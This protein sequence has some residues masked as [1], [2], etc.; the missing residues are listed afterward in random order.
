MAAS[1]VP[2]AF[3][4]KLWF[5]CSTSAGGPTAVC[6]LRRAAVLP[7]SPSS[8]SSLFKDAPEVCS[9]EVQPEQQ[10]VDGLR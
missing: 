4:V 10:V 6:R 2:T 5:S 8:G 7:N 9:S 3:C 1:S